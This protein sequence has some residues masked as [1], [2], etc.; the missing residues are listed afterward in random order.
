MGGVDL[1]PSVHVPSDEEPVEPRLDEVALVCGRVGAQQLGGIDVVV[2]RSAPGRVIGRG[3]E[4][5][6]VLLRGDHGAD[7]VHVGE[8]GVARSSDV[9][10]VEVVYHAVLDYLHGMVGDVVKLPLHFAEDGSR[11][12]RC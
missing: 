6:E 4:T 10:F 3:E 11:N 12:I 8:H 9:L 7:V 2:V 1:I 5:V